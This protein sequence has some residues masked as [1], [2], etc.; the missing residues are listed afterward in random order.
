MAWAHAFASWRIED[1][2]IH[3]NPGSVSRPGHIPQN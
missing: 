1:V 3:K 2:G